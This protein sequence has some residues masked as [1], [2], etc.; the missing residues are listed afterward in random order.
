MKLNKDDSDV[1]YNL[2]FIYQSGQGVKQDYGKARE[3][4][5]RADKLNNSNA[6]FTLALMYQN[7][8]G[9]KQDINKF[10]EYSDKL[11]LTNYILFEKLLTDWKKED[12][13]KLIKLFTKDRNEKSH[14]IEQQKSRIKYLEDEL[15]AKK[16]E[17]GGE[18]YFEAKADFEQCL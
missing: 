1:L 15:L 17:P 2:G 5:E 3:L 6:T 8:Q 12:S 13:D 9:V 4:Y 18:G 10:I 14:L 11:Y 7:G 16:Y